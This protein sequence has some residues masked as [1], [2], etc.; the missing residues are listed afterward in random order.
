M[1]GNRE[2]QLATIG[3]GTEDD[4]VQMNDLG[5]GWMKHLMKL[6]TGF[7]CIR[8]TVNTIKALQTWFL[9]HFQKGKNIEHC[10]MHFVK[11]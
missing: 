1:K 3:C 11:L 10:Y 8:Q 2:E 5:T 7:N 6:L 4:D 9:C